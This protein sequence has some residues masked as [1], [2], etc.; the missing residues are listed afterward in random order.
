MTLLKIIE[1]LSINSQ[2]MGR[3][4]VALVL[5]NISLCF[6]HNIAILKGVHL[7]ILTINISPLTILNKVLLNI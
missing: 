5:I 4:V 1:G 2:N 6:K 3:A 7:S